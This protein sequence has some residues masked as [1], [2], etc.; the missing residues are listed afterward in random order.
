MHTDTA[1]V[2]T[3]LVLCYAAMSGLVKRWYVAPGLIFVAFGILLGPFGFHVIDPGDDE[4]AF[5]VLA[6]LALTVDPVQPGRRAGRAC[7]AAASGDS[8]SDCWCWVSR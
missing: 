6:Q 3:A 1:I 8:P 2:L 5:T 4:H 7:R